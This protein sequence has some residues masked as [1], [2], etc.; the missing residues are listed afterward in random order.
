VSYYYKEEEIIKNELEY[1]FPNLSCDSQDEKYNDKLGVIDFETFGNNI[2]V[3]YTTVLMVEK[4]KI[5]VLYIEENKSSHNLVRRVV[6][7]IF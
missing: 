2:N 4:G 5:K 3:F 6:D 7:S 1:N